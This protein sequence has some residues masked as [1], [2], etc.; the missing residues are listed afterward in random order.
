MSVVRN[1]KCPS[2]SSI[3]TCVDIHIFRVD[4]LTEMM[5]YIAL[6]VL[7]DTRGVITTVDHHA[8]LLLVGFLGRNNWIIVKK[9]YKLVGSRP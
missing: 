1:S 5:L 8:L 4:R 7:Y 9:I 2:L 6:H 3:E